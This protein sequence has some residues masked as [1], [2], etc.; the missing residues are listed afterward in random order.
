MAPL[1]IAAAGLLACASVDLCGTLHVH[2][3]GSTNCLKKPF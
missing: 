1:I 2:I 3:L